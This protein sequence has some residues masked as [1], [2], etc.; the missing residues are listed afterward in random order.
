MR[1]RISIRLLAVLLAVAVTA[2]CSDAAS[3]WHATTYDE[4]HC[5]ACQAAHTANVHAPA[6]PVV[7]P[8]VPLARFVARDDRAPDL[9]PARTR[10]IP[11]APP[12]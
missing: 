1:R 10:S 2:L 11:R 5:Q 4:L 6:P 3:H 8:P 9:E 7:R 12:A